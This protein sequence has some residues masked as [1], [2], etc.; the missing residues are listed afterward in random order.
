VP[1]QPWSRRW[2]FIRLARAVYNDLVL[3]GLLLGL[4]AL[5]SC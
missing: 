5:L 4:L 3:P 2:R 1:L